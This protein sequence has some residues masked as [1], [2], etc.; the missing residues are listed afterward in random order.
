GKALAYSNIV[1]GRQALG[2]FEPEAGARMRLPL[3]D[4]LAGGADA[5]AVLVQVESGGL[6]GKILGAASLAL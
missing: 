1:T 3:A 2:M 4:V 5:I 6:P